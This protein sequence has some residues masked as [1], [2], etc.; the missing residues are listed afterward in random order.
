MKIIKTK[1]GNEFVVKSGLT[2]KEAIKQIAILADAVAMESNY[3][4]CENEDDVI[5]I[6]DPDT[7]RIIFE[8]G[9][10]IANIGDVQLEIVSD[11]HGKYIVVESFSQKALYFNQFGRAE[12]YKENCI[13][14]DTEEKAK[15]WINEM[16]LSEV[17]HI[18]TY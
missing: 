16:D 17:A 10:Q 6:S 18:E 4:Q 7:K 12:K 15:E 2:E 9:E 14:F 11:E 1:K 13:T 5:T 3:Y 8:E